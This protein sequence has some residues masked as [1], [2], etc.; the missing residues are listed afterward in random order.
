MSNDNLAA[1]QSPF[2]TRFDFETYCYHAYAKNLWFYVGVAIL[3]ALISLL[4]SYYIWAVLGIAIICALLPIPLFRILKW[5]FSEKP[6]P[7]GS[8]LILF[9]IIQLVVLIPFVIR[10]KSDKSLFELLT[11]SGN[12]ES[13]NKPQEWFVAKID[14][15]SRKAIVGTFTDYS[16]REVQKL[17]KDKKMVYSIVIPSRVTNEQ[18]KI[19]MDEAIV[20]ITADDPDIDELIL[21]VYSSKDE[22][23]GQRWDIG[24]AIWAYEGKLGG[25]TP[26]IV[27]SNNRTN[28]ATTYRFE[29]DDL[30]SY[31]KF[32][33]QVEVREGIP[34]ARRLA[35]YQA[36]IR[37]TSE[38]TTKLH[39]WS[40]KHQRNFSIAEYS[41][42]QDRLWDQA[43]SR[44]KKR[45]HIS[46]AELTKINTE[47]SEKHWPMGLKDTEE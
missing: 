35:I 36:L 39:T 31:L 11:T 23:T 42:H 43:E 4:C 37:E 18:A 3:A 7:L 40:V 46:D 41:H 44:V 1:K 17:P 30:L 34:Q 22:I 14:D 16:Y 8:V 26:E 2:P 21:D 10:D 28:Y 27:T 19:V 6:Y 20:K 13:N 32:K 5:Q 38:A 25:M 45:F 12:K 24:E 15:H 33:N 47:G 29:H 9:T